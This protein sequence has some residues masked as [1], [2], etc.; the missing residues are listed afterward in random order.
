MNA[1]H[2]LSRLVFLVILAGA[3]AAWQGGDPHGDLPY[4]GG[5]LNCH[6]FNGTPDG[7]A[8]CL[9]CH[10]ESPLF[11]S[12]GATTVEQHAHTDT[13][14]TSFEYTL[15][16]TSCH[17]PHDQEQDIA[18]GTTYGK[19]IR[20][21]IDE[22][23]T[24]TDYTVSPP[25]VFSKTISNPIEFTNAFQFVDGDADF[26]EDI[27]STCHTLTNH[28]QNDGS[29]PGGQFHYDGTDCTTCHSHQDGFAPGS[30]PPPP[31]HD[32]FACS[33]CH[34]VGPGGTLL[35]AFVGAPI[36]NSMCDACHGIGSPAFMAG[37]SDLDVETHHG[38]TYL[39]PTTGQLTF[40]DCVECH[41][42]MRDQFNFRG[43]TNLSFVR[44][45]IA[46]TEIA[47]ESETGPYGFAYDLPD[48]PPDMGPENYVCNTCHTQTNHHQSS[49]FA[50]AGQEHYD[51]LDCTSCHAHDAGFEPIGGGPHPEASTD[52]SN[53]HLDPLSGQQDLVGMHAGDCSLCHTT[54]FAAATFTFLGPNGSWDGEC[55]ACHNPF[56]VETGQFETP[57]KGHRCV[58]CHGVQLSTADVQVFHED[59][60][61][62]ANCV[63]CHGFVPDTGVV[64]GSGNRENCQLCHG[65]KHGNTPST[66]FHKRMASKGTSC[67][68]C[69]AL[70]RPP[71]DVVVS[72][73]VGTAVH[74]C[75]VCHDNRVPEDFAKD[76]ERYH[77]RHAGEQIGCGSCHLDATLQEDHHP[78]P[79]VDDLR[80]GLVNRAG[81]NECSHC[82]SSVKS[83]TSPEVHERHVGDQ[84]Q[85]CYDC[86]EGFDPRP[87]GQL[88]PVT[89]PG[90]ACELC[91]E[92]ETY[93]DAFPFGVHLEHAKRAKCYAC[94]Q[95]VPPLFDWP[96]TWK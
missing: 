38:D 33:V 63:V 32:Q 90:E 89:Q 13:G 52:C 7:T 1:L 11:P 93:G 17:H 19:Y 86:H 56:V 88:P 65:S 72:A 96:D 83:T 16:C 42:P 27:C 82:H 58:V 9:W 87:L 64:I 30:I 24:V 12:Y 50:P 68:E 84:W 81:T 95:A 14:T 2:L 48:A 85:W 25:Q 73:P 46:G 31:P 35:D 20:R 21:V 37:G 29:A 70:G 45:V 77:E 43:N 47:F 69:H 67:I 8:T 79:P 91:H 34:L 10:G 59:H 78:M 39:D 44:A 18:F 4:F 49:G 5:C 15:D 40:L 36:A 94:H 75:Q 74:V 3:P 62:E 22:T 61:D 53:C 57:T 66:S 23:I 76:P 54:G 41:N 71:V 26:T 51:G 92:D 6:P 60:S 55:S 80:R 28:H